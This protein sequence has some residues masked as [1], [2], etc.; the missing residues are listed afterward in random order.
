MGMGGA[1]KS[2]GA[3]DTGSV[4]DS[5]ILWANRSLNYVFL[6]N[7]IIRYK[8]V[9]WYCLKDHVKTETTEPG[10]DTGNQYWGGIVKI[11]EKTTLF[12]FIWTPSYTSSFQHKP[13]VS[14]I[15][16]GNGYEQRIGK[17]INPDLKT[18]QL[19]FDQRTSREARAIIYFLQQ[20]ASIQA[21]AYNPG[22]IYSEQSYRTK[23]VCRE[24]ETNFTF[25]ENY[26][27]RAKFEEVSA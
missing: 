16:F 12:K 22:D 10:T 3:E 7:D 8:N 27:I 6:K 14:T 11:N 26:S 5:M 20:R 21:F 2:F 4:N 25:K 13:S 19:N 18:L 9:V 23:Y 15:R 17:S 24:W 1:Q